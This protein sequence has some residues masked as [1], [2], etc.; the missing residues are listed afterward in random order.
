[1]ISKRH[2]EV[3]KVYTCDPEGSDLLLIGKM[4]A[5]TIQGGHTVTE[6][7]G[8]M[9]MEHTVEGLRINLY[10]TWA[11]CIH[12]HPSAFFEWEIIWP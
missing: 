8:R 9:V 12:F 10:Q 4:A 2:H 7:V 1:M 5:Y 3:L 11:V 6:F